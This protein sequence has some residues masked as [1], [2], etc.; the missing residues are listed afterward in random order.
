MA[1]IVTAI[2]SLRPTAEFALVEDDYANITW[3]HLDGK[4]PT[5]AEIN[6]EIARLNDLEASAEAAKTAAKLSAEAKLSALGLT[7]D[8]IA[9]LK[10]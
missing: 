1:T 3:H 4:A 5:I 7:S 8:E 10:A 2:Q 6:A 9:A